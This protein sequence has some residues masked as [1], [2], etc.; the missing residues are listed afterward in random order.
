[1][2]NGMLSC[3]SYADRLLSA[4]LGEFLSL[5]PVLALFPAVFALH[6]RG[7]SPQPRVLKMFVLQT[8]SPWLSLFQYFSML[9][10]VSARSVI[11]RSP[12][13]RVHGQGSEVE[14]SLF[15]DI[16]IRWSSDYTPLTCDVYQQ[17]LETGVEAKV[18]IFSE[19]NY[20]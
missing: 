13:N 20:P 15:H 6:C 3:H 16:D 12:I 5:V 19:W 4:C 17:D 11:F 10:L 1:M 18:N 8:R 7:S 9:T 14:Y 2:A